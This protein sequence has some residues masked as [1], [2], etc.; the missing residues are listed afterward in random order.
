MLSLGSW[1]ALTSRVSQRIKRC[2]N[3]GSDVLCPS[4][5]ITTRVR[6]HRASKARFDRDLVAPCGAGIGKSRNCTLGA[7]R[8]VQNADMIAWRIARATLNVA[9]RWSASPLFKSGPLQLTIAL[10]DSGNDLKALRPDRAL[11]PKQLCPSEILAAWGYEGNRINPE[12]PR[13]PLHTVRYSVAPPLELILRYPEF[14]HPRG[15][16]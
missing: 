3:L 9:R 7:K 1:R 4:V 11:V 13:R 8:N 10:R 15:I 12:G 16:F 5:S 2:W 14:L 6:R